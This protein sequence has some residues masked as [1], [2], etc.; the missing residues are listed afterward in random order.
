V[1]G[2]PILPGVFILG[3]IYLVVN[4]IVTHPVWTSVTFAIVLAGI[5]VYFVSFARRPPS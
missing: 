2:Y 5:P 3:V 4:A 1:P